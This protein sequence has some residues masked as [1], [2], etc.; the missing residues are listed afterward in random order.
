MATSGP[1]EENLEN[2]ENSQ[3]ESPSNDS[4]EPSQSSTATAPPPSGSFSLHNRWLLIGA[5]GGGVVLLA[6]IAVVAFMFL[7]GDLPMPQQTM[8]LVPEDA[9]QVIARDTQAVI[10][11]EDFAESLG[12][13]GDDLERSV[14]GVLELDTAEITDEVHARMPSSNYLR[15]YAGNFQFEDIRDDLDDAGHEESSYRGYEVW[16]GASYYVLLEEAGYV[17]FSDSEDDVEDAVG[18][19]YRGEGSMADA[20]DNDL[21]LIL[22]KLGY[23]PQIYAFDDSH[24]EVLSRCQGYGV[25]FTGYDYDEEETG[26]QLAVLFSSERAAESAA[27]DYDD[28]ADF[29]EHNLLILSS[30]LDIDDL[31]NEGTFVVGQAMLKAP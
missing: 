7:G 21:K 17:I 12:I 6:V 28:V 5:A 2:V 15:I 14:V 26:A 22:D 20:E 3:P 10:S 27:D 30:S 25:A 19:L 4:P 9:T 13:T 16:E 29:I 31:K 1:P 18:V 24:C 8:E 11:D 23:A